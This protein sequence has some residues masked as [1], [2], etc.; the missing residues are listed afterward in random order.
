MLLQFQQFLVVVTISIMV[1]SKNCLLYRSINDDRQPLNIQH[2][3]M[4]IQHGFY[5]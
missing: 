4:K 3:I 1:D 2:G 5:E